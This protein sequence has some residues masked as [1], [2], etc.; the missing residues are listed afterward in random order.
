VKI[1]INALK[2][3]VEFSK[4]DKIIWFYKKFNLL[5]LKFKIKFNGHNYVLKRKRFWSANVDLLKDGM[6]VGEIIYEYEKATIRLSGSDVFTLLSN[7]YNAS[8]LEI[9]NQ[10]DKVV[11]QLK[12][13]GSMIWKDI[14]Y[15]VKVLDQSINSGDIDEFM[16]Y[17]AYALRLVDFRK[18]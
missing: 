14:D 1:K 8:I 13:N 11:I 12:G 16:I 9:K 6:N 4:A 10:N 15:Q 17:C 2:S 5:S 18:D 3:K 7:L